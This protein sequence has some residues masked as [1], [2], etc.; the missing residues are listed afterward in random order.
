MIEI[1]D[2]YDRRTAAGLLARASLAL[3][4]GEGGEKSIVDNEAAVREA[5]IA[6]ARLKLGI[7]PDDEGPEVIEQIGSYFDD[8]SDRL[9]GN[10][11][12][13][14]AF[15]RLITRGDLP[16]DLYDIRII[17][18]V[19]NLYGK[20]FERERVFIERTIRTP[21]KEQHFGPPASENEPY[22]ISLFAREFKTPYPLRDFTMLVAGK[23]ML[24]RT[25]EIHQAWRLYGSKVNLDNPQ[26]LVEL[27]RRFADVY[28][29]DILVDGQRGRFFLTAKKVERTT[30]LDIPAGREIMVTHFGQ[31]NPQSGGRYAALVVAIDL[32]LYRATLDKLDYKDVS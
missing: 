2:H 7:K 24:E 26:D 31:T 17:P 23:R 4:S 5:L 8:E 14:A 13:R 25:L 11:H 32:G 22:L 29:A 1:L 18:N 21:T 15:E 20:K 3:Q 28:G 6:Q 27:L 9:A 19:Q 16:S 10:P 12:T 30:R